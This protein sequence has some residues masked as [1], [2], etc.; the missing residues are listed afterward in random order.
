MRNIN[1][2]DIN[3]NMKKTVKEIMSWNVKQGTGP[4][5]IHA[6]ALQQLAFE[7]DAC[8]HEIKMLRQGK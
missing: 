8:W 4:V 3:E 1:N 7:L 2:Q 5:E 6:Y